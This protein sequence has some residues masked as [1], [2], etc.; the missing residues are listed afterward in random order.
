[1]VTCP[2]AVAAPL[3]T[4]SIAP[5]LQTRREHDPDARYTNEDDECSGEKTV[6]AKQR[7]ERA[8]VSPTHMQ[9]EPHTETSYL[10]CCTIALVRRHTVPTH[11][12]VDPPPHLGA[13]LPGH[14]RGGCCCSDS[15]SD[16][17]A[18]CPADDRRAAN[19]REAEGDA[20]DGSGSRPTACD[21]DAG[22]PSVHRRHAEK[23]RMADDQLHLHRRR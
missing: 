8:C 13:L 11:H 2:Q 4:K 16:A 22:K 9:P 12:E 21:A 19:G 23:R 18:A 5:S 20:F 15:V 3:R 17:A 6:T 1:M 14:R 7:A 10:L